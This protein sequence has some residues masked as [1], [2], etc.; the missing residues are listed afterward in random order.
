MPAPQPEQEAHYPI[1]AENMA[2]MARL[3][4]Q[5]RI[6]TQQQGLFPANLDL[7]QKQSILDIGCGPG[8]WVL[9]VA[10]RYPECWVTGVDV[11]KIMLAYAQHMARERELLNTR[12]RAMDARS[13]LDFPEAT[14]D[15][16]HSRLIMGFM[17][18]ATWPPFFRECYRLLRPGGIVCST[19]VE[20]VGASSSP[21]FSHYCNLMVKAM[22]LAG[23]CFSPEGSQ[24]G[25][26][27]VQARLLQEAGFQDIG[28]E[29]HILNYSAGQPA[30]EAIYDDCRTMLKLIQPFLVSC[31]LGTSA[32]LEVLYERAMAEMQA[33]DFCAVAYSQRIWGVKPS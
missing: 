20:N 33:P 7:S 23:Q 32:E 6:A 9:S 3:V 16:V 18:T 1:E 8:E 4:K 19:E 13:G 10:E 17:S 14:F 26:T 5:A 25:I 11:S 22:R 27:A 29:A 30:H 12:F 15:V 28:Q 2:E 31:Q 21:S 24:I